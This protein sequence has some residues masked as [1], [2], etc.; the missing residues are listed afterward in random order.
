MSASSPIQSPRTPTSSASSSNSS[1]HTFGADASPALHQYSDAL[2]RAMEARFQAVARAGS[3]AKLPEDAAHDPDYG[4]DENPFDTRA[5]LLQS[6]GDKLEGASRSSESISSEPT[7]D[8][9]PTPEHPAEPL[10]NMNAME[11]TLNSPIDE[12]FI[13][14]G[15]SRTSS[16]YPSSLEADS[17]LM[18]RSASYNG[19][20]T[21][22]SEASFEAGR[23]SDYLSLYGRTRSPSATPSSIGSARFR[24]QLTPLTPLTPGS[25]NRRRRYHPYQ[26][27]TCEWDEAVLTRTTSETM[28]LAAGLGAQRQRRRRVDAGAAPASGTPAAPSSAPHPSAQV[29]AA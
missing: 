29:Q 18:S 12:S 26:E 1:R 10:N 2:R 17:A 20:D 19:C 11:V 9:P 25:N 13:E 14:F 21:P 3:N 23:A 28:L 27:T 15:R 7:V 24:Q 8:G 4:Y 22:S 6:F 16:S 5:R